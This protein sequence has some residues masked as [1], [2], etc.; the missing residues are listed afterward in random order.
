M[1]EIEIEEHLN[2]QAEIEKKLG[3]FGRVTYFIKAIVPKTIKRNYTRTQS[4]ALI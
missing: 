2:K 3:I 4:A 1:T